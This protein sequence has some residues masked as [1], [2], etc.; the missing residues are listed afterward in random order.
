M[1]DFLVS[2]GVGASLLFSHAF[3]TKIAT[4]LMFRTKLTDSRTPAAECDK[5][6]SSWFYK[7]YHA[8]QMNEFEYAAA[9][10]P[11]MLF[12]HS[13]GIAAPVSSSMA[14]GGQIWYVRATRARRACE[15]AGMRALLAARR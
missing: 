2:S 1:S 5:I 9:F 6:E 8:A 12:L 11:A 10:V 13:K 7:R 3:V 15:C 4:T 14:V